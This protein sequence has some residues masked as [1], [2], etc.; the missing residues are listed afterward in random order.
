T[1][2]GHQQQ[3]KKMKPS[4]TSTFFS[5]GRS[6]NAPGGLR[7]SA[8]ADGLNRIAPKHFVSKDFPFPQPQ[9]DVKPISISAPEGLESGGGGTRTR[10]ILSNDFA[11]ALTVRPLSLTSL[12]PTSPLSSPGSEKENPF[13]NRRSRLSVG[14]IEEAGEVG[15]V[16]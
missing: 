5:F 12:G 2:H 8:S 4:T 14:T 15:R 16:E 3:Q 6:S 7:V 11:K 1:V 13:G 9:E 10:T